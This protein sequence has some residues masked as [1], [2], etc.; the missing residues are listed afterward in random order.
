MTDKQALFIKTF[1]E[2]AFPMLKETPSSD[3][4]Y[5]VMLAEYDY[6]LM[7]QAA[8]NYIKRSVYTPTI[9]GIIQ[10]YETLKAIK[11]A[12]NQKKLV[13]IINQMDDKKWFPPNGDFTK[14]SE[15]EKALQMVVDGNISEDLKKK[16]LTFA[17]NNNEVKLLLE[18]NERKGE[19]NA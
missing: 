16:I 6:D 9:A 12:E 17:R 8:K 5:T 18:N 15:Y 7:F 3:M 19:A 1:L 10:E 4:T 2:G 14:L 13:E 11:Q